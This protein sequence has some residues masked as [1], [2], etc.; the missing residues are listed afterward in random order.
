MITS[1]LK[2]IVNTAAKGIATINKIEKFKQF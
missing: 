2:S 1:L